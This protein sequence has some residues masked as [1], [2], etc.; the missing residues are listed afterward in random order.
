MFFYMEDKNCFIHSSDSFLM[1]L[2]PNLEAKLSQLRVPE[3]RIPEI[4]ARMS[5]REDALSTQDQPKQ[6]ISLDVLR[7]IGYSVVGHKDPVDVTIT[8]LAGEL[9]HGTSTV[10]SRFDALVDQWVEAVERP[11]MRW[12]KHFDV[13]LPEHTFSIRDALRCEYTVLTQYAP[14]AQDQ[15]VSPRTHGLQVNVRVEVR[16]GGSFSHHSYTIGTA[17]EQHVRREGFLRT[18]K[19]HYDEPKIF[20]T[21]FGGSPRWSYLPLRDYIRSLLTEHRNGADGTVPLNK[22]KSL[23]QI[24]TAVRSFYESIHRRLDDSAEPVSTPESQQ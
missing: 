17:R 16:E 7:D 6:G 13:E 14:L 1:G 10:S 9:S 19:T 8:E 3:E 23:L 15:I 24:D 18:K 5:L 21:R 4:I 22:L 11:L 2:E 12:N 20:V